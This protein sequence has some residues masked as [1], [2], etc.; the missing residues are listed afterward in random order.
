M[1]RSYTYNRKETSKKYWFTLLCNT[2]LHEESLKTIYFS[3]V[4]YYLNYD[5]IVWVS[6]YYAKPNKMHYQQKHAAQHIFSHSRPLLQLF[7]AINVYQISLYQYL[8]F[9]YKFNNKQTF[10]IF[11][12]SHWKTCPSISYSVF[13]NQF[14]FEKVIFEYY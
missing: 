4:H 14:Q 3:Y 12:W 9:M 1:E 5:N 6:T 13:E 10:I 11:L 8:N 7:N 2:V